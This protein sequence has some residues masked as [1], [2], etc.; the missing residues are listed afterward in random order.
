MHSRY[1]GKD[2]IM[3]DEKITFVNGEP[4]K[5]GCQM[6]FSS[7]GAAADTAMIAVDGI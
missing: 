4:A 1:S 6:E 5:C 3:P 7:G 2:E